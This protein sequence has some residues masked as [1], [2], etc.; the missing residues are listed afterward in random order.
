MQVKGTESST[1]EKVLLPT[2]VTERS[3]T[4]VN[5]SAESVYKFHIVSHNEM[6]NSQQPSI[7]EVDKKSNSESTSESVL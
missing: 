7:I 2:V 4:F 6:G 5:L 3:A 1:Q